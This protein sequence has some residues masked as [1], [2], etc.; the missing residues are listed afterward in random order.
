MSKTAK[1]T[2]V[3]LSDD[4]VAK[5]KTIQADA[6]LEKFVSKAVRAYLEILGERRQYEQLTK[7]YAT[8]AYLYDELSAEVADEVWSRLKQDSSSCA[9]KVSHTQGFYEN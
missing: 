4:L 8:S 7:D 9:E 1:A 5:I 3:T 2:T 6:D